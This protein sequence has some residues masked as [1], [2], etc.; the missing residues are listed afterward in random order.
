MRISPLNETILLIFL[1]CITYGAL[2]G[3]SR[4]HPWISPDTASYVEAWLSTSPW[5]EPRHP[6]FG[7]LL[8]T[9]PF[10]EKF[11][12]FP[13]IMASLFFASVGYLHWSL[14]KIGLSL[15]ASFSVTTALIWSNAFLIWHNAV[16]PEI[17]A[18][19]MIFCAI[20]ALNTLARGGAFAPN[21]FVFTCALGTACML[22]PSFL[23]CLLFFPALYTFLQAATMRS[24]RWRS[25]AAILLAAFIPFLANSTLR[26]FAVGD[27]NIVSFGGFQMVGMAGLIQTPEIE[28]LMPPDL[29]P[30]AHAII[31]QR[32]E[33]EERG[34]ILQTPLNS[35]GQ[36]SF[37]SSA[38]GYFDIYARTY[39]DLLYGIIRPLQGNEDWPSFNRKMM[40]FSLATVTAAP[41][42]YL[43]WVGGA[44]SRAV[45]RMIVTNAPLALAVVFLAAL[46]PAVLFRGR[47]RALRAAGVYDLPIL[48]CLTVFYTVSSIFLSV[49][50]TY[51]ASRYIDTA[52]IFLPALPIYAVMTLISALMEPEQHE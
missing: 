25:A 31:K 11:N 12:R 36:R 23:P 18:L 46:Y 20:A 15:R 14:R 26:Y 49:I 4:F 10:G 17:L 1:A 27:F 48:L 28:K 38:L 42:E 6:L 50:V 7:W 35:Q 21:I 33:G 32:K 2:F 19:S 30:F 43:A 5:G 37:V 47:Q 8:D 16:H 29:Q 44:M 45:G 52:A 41:T 13:I 22:R 51:P 3:V 24:V 9:L 39:D 34:Y 40:R